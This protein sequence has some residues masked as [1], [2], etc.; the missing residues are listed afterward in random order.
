ISHIPHSNWKSS[1]HIS[2]RIFELE[3]NIT[4]QEI[5]IKIAQHMIQPNMKTNDSTERNIVMQMNIWVKEKRQ[6][7]YQ[8]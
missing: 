4:V 1:E 7:F 5:Q 3:M 8:Y 6:L 2:W